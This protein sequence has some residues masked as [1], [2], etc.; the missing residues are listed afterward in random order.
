[1]S[2]AAQP[3]QPK[4]QLL[5]PWKVVLHN[6]NVNDGVIVAKRVHEFTPLTEIE[7]LTKTQEAHVEGEAV[8]FVT[9]RE[10]A[11]LAEEQFK[12][13]SPPITVTIEPE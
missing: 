5:P 13:C 10:R 9:N 8:L 11:E 3:T 2:T 4:T 12:S 7:S 6:D 1:M